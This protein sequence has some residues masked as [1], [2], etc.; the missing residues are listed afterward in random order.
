MVAVECIKILLLFKVIFQ[1]IVDSFLE[2]P[3]R[4]N[5]GGFWNFTSQR[6]KKIRRLQSRIDLLN[7]LRKFPSA[8]NTLKATKVK[9]TFITFVFFCSDSILLHYWVS[10]SVSPWSFMFGLISVSWLEVEYIF[11]N[12]FFNL[13]IFYE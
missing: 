1:Q 5:A 11:N 9:V 8:P 12:D 10:Y 2:L 13:S 7:Q 4:K 6:K 3:L